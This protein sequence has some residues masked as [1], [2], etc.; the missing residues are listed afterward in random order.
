MPRSSHGF[1]TLLVRVVISVE[2]RMRKRVEKHLVGKLEIDAVLSG[3][4][5][6]LGRVPFELVHVTMFQ[7]MSN[8]RPCMRPIL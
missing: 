2:F 7:L 4:A 5:R 1:P 6:V 8:R 3:I